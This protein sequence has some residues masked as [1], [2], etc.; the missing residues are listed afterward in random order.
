MNYLDRNFIWWAIFYSSL[1]HLIVLVGFTFFTPKPVVKPMKTVEVTYK[2]ITPKPIQTPPDTF[3]EV[4]VLKKQEV[5]RDFKF[6]LD[7]PTI[8]FHQE[9]L[10]DSTKSGDDFKVAKKDNPRLDTISER[11][12]SIPMIQAEKITNPKYLSYNE[13]IRQRIRQR[14]YS[15]VDSPE[16]QA[17]EVYLT[18][19]IG[20][21][22][23]LKECK[24]IDH[25]TRANQ[26][27]R[28]VGLLSVQES[29]PFP[30]FP[31][32]LNYPELTFNVVIAFEIEEK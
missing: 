23:A 19:I 25:K 7:K 31:A 22:G 20:S 3:K 6:E 11:R 14:A 8:P 13:N 16:F 18:F 21:D 26:Y 12:I 30:P 10:R 17:G 27:L 1:I 15:Y 28:R 29:N 4:K 9:V 32:D 5:A 24:I 2:K